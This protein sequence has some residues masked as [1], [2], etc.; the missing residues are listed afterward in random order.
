MWRRIIRNV[1]SNFAGT[2]VGLAIGFFMMP[3][4][5]SRIGA[6]AFGLWMIATSVFGSLGVF[7]STLAPTLVKKAAQHLARD[8]VHGR[9]ELNETVSTVLALYALI[10]LVVGL[11]TVV[12][13]V[14]ADRI[15]WIPAESLATFRTVLMVIGIQAAIGCPMSVWNSLLAARQEFHVL[16]G[17]GMATNLARAIL[18][19]WLLVQGFGLVSLVWSGLA[20]SLLGWLASAWWVRRRVPHLEVWPSLCRTSRIRDL[21]R[22]S[23]AM[24]VWSVAGYALHQMDRVLIGMA[25]PVQAITT[26]EIGARLAGYSR[27]VLHSWLSVVM[28]AA[29]DLAARDDRGS[30][31]EVFLVGTRYL[32]TSYAA[33]SIV[34]VGFGQPFIAL[35]MGDGYAQS[36]QVLVILVAGGLFQS[37]NVVAHVMLPAMGELRAF[38]RIMAAYP[39]ATIA[40]TV[41]AMHA[42]GLLGVPAGIAM[43]MVLMETIFSR[44]ILR[45]FGVSWS[46]LLRACHLPV[47]LSALPALT[48]VVLARA[49]VPIESWLALVTAVAMTLALHALG[50]L[51]LG[52]SSGERR[53]LVS[54]LNAAVPLRAQLAPRAAEVGLSGAAGIDVR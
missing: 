17:L 8:D 10:G 30:L 29:S 6:T 31:R 22:F 26:Y 21:G 32:L 3:F 11:A 50:F 2:M 28:P 27:N 33:V 7:D 14:V 5:V 51:G 37:Q 16:N 53:A 4:V 46:D 18:T 25:F 41:T 48:W 35:W 45:V 20:L 15:F 36:F 12:L 13:S 19:W 23:G 47:L 1:L 44:A 9:A 40:L 43:T 52:M 39:I 34:L 24:L 42:W 54:A 38:T 49:A